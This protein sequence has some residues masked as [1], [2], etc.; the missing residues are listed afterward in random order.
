M[1]GLF[2]WFIYDQDGNRL[3]DVSGIEPDP[4]LVQR[5]LERAKEVIAQMG[6]KWCC[7]NP[8]PPR[9]LEAE[10]ELFQQRMREIQK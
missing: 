7:W 9:D 6:K 2:D 1:S 5:N 3:I 4:E 10:E 8:N